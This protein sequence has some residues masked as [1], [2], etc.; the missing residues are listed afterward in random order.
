M[1]GYIVY[2]YLEGQQVNLKDL[3]KELKI[4][5]VDMEHTVSLSR[6]GW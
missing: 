2:Y 4:A 5:D 6:R 1:K 3:I